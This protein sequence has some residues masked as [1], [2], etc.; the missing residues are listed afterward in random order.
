MKK[1]IICLFIVILAREMKAQDVLLEQKVSEEP[2]ERGPN[3]RTYSHFFLEYGFMAGKA[4]A[5]LNLNTPGSREV[6]LGYRSKLKL[7][8]ILAIGFDLS[9]RYDKFSISQKNAQAFPDTMLGLTPMKHIREKLAFHSLSIDPFIRINFDPNRGNILGYYL[10]LGASGSYAVSNELLM[11]D[12][13]ANDVKVKT[14]YTNLPFTEPLQY[15][16]FGRL[17]FNLI[18]ISA[19]YR[20]SSYFKEDLKL[21]EP[22]RLIVSLMLNFAR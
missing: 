5:G 12:K 21:P 8:S 13:A 18:T 11:Q 2:R 19:S 16:V 1:L 20:L 7:T 3:T 22:P 9:Y 15:G 10:D 17:G 14:R 6:R 4:D